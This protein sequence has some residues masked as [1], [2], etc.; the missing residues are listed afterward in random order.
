M[1]AIFQAF[2]VFAHVAGFPG[3]VTRKLRNVVPILIMGINEDHRI[4]RR[5]ASQSAAPGIED[6]VALGGELRV[7]FLSLVAGVMPDKEILLQR[8]VLRRQRVKRG[9]FIV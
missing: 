7:F 8:L 5:A 2:E 4:M 9:D 1:A 6:T 3:S